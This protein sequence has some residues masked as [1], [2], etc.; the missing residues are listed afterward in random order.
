MPMPNVI[1]LENVNAAIAKATILTD[2]HVMIDRYQEELNDVGREVELMPGNNRIS[3]KNDK[4]NGPIPLK[5]NVEFQ[6]KLIE[7]VV[8]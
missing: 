2:N 3:I 6:D 5:E 4:V 1:N 8:E 7:E